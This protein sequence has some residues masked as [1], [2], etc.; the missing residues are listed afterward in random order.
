MEL[1]RRNALVLFVD[2]SEYN[3][4][5][6][7]QPTPPIAVS[8]SF[9]PWRAAVAAAAVFLFLLLLLRA[10]PPHPAPLLGGGKYQKNRLQRRRWRLVQL[11]TFASAWARSDFYLTFS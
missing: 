8:I 5:T 1:I 9:C 10:P 6:G 7:T 4:F 3:N 2:D 11:D